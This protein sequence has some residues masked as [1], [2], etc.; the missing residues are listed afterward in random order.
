MSDG[1][2][3]CWLGTSSSPNGPRPRHCQPQPTN[4]YTASNVSVVVTAD[5][6]TR[7]G[8]D[9]KGG[10]AATF[11]IAVGMRFGQRAQEQEHV[12]RVRVGKP[13]KNS[14]C[15]W[16]FFVDRGGLGSPVL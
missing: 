14:R 4:D 3:M 9:R 11:F 15:W 1:N 12:L 5:R 2:N 10:A 6:Q 13:G 8:D 7:E 16:R